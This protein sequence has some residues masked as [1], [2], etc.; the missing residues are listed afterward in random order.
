MS[1]YYYHFIANI[2]QINVRQ[3]PYGRTNSE[4]YFWC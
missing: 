2:A 4:I 3:L 1:I